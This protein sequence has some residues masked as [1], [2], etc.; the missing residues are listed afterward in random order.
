[1][2]APRVGGPGANRFRFSGRLRGRSLRPGRYLLSATPRGV[3]KPGRT[4]STGFRIA[5]PG[6]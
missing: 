3:G 1:M 4:R 5:R 2:R 6:R